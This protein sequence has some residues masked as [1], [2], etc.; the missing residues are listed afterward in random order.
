MDFEEYARIKPFNRSVADAWRTGFEDVVRR[1]AKPIEE[2]DL[3]D[4][5]CGDGKY[6]ELL[7]QRGLRPDRIHGVDVSTIRIE[8]CRDMGWSHARCI[9]PG[10]PLSFANRS[11]DV[12]NMME[13]VE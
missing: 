2:I 9:E 5:G 11:F 7:I 10:K 6:Y 1:V 4:Y 12:V 13:V 8:R 3:L